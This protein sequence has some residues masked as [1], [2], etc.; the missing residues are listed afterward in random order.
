MTEFELLDKLLPENLKIAMETGRADK[1]SQV[2]TGM[3]SF[4]FRDIAEHLGTKIA[5]RHHSNRVI[6]RGLLALQELKG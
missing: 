1:I 2:Q 4:E 6:T 5:E 3:M